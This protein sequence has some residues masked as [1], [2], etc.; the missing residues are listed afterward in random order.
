MSYPSGPPSGQ[1]GGYPG[2][3][4]QQGGSVFGRPPA[5]PSPMS[6]L[7]TQG[8]LTLAVAV[9]GLAAYLSSFGGG[10]GFEVLVLLA[11]ALLAAL[12]LLPKTPSLLLW[13]TVLSVIGGLGFLDVVISSTQGGLPVS[14]ILVLVFGLL[15][16]VAAVTTLLLGYGVI[17][18]NPRPAVPHTPGYRAGGYPP[19][20]GQ[21]Q[22]PQQ[23]QPAQATQFMGQQGQQVQQL[24]GQHAQQQG[25]QQGQQ[26]QATQFLQHPGQIS[27]PQTPPG[28]HEYE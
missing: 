21:Q 12:D 14:Y 8:L 11:A 13:A 25:Q 22:H 9:L 6:R 20:G 24:G 16:A 3:H 26:P 15:Q 7:G 17:K 1:P 19:Q 27:H 2:Q 5:T 4:P 18:A 10:Y 28:G 23:Q